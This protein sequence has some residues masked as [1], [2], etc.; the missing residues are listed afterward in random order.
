MGKKRQKKKGS[1]VERKAALPVAAGREDKKRESGLGLAELEAAL[2]EVESRHAQEEASFIAQLQDVKS[3]AGYRLARRGGRGGALARSGRY[4]EALKWFSGIKDQTAFSFIF[5]HHMRGCYAALGEFKQ[6]A[7]C[8][9]EI[10]RIRPR[11]LDYRLEAFDRGIDEKATYHL[12]DI[13]VSAERKREAT[14]LCNQGHDF[15]RNG[16]FTAAK[17]DFERAIRINPG[18]AE[19]HNGLGNVY[20]V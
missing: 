1:V 3:E 18:D 13:V 15:G 5:L 8:L 16:N 7:S 14:A 11:N 6:A 2:S 10:K 17:D 12:R 4:K 9:A 19:A 20:S